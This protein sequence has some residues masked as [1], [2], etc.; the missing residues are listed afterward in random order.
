MK[1]ESC[2]GC[3]KVIKWKIASKEL[4]KNLKSYIRL[5]RAENREPEQKEAKK[6]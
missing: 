4:K 5:Q 1:E 6:P 3:G 2:G